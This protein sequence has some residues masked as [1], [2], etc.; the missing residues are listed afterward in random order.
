[1]IA[2][3]LYDVLVHVANPASFSLTDSF[4]Y[5]AIA[6]LAGPGGLA[7]VAASVL[8]LTGGQQFLAHLNPTLDTVFKYLGPAALV[9]NLAVYRRGFN[10]AFRDFG[11][12]LHE[13]ALTR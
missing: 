7:G 10:G 2:S 12:L 6:V 8:L 3:G 13:R 11:Q 4:N 9:L 5:L 1:G